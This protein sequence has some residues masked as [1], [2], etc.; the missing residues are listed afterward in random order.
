MFLSDLLCNNDFDVNC[1]VEVY[2][3]TKPDKQHKNQAPMLYTSDSNSK[4]LDSVSHMS[5]IYVT[6][7][8]NRL[9]IEVTK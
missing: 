4:P 8:N 9:I 1:V 5:I 3:C 2:D 6:I 7:V